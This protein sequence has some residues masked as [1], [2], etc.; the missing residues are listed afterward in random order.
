MLNG[1]KFM[2]KNNIKRNSMFKN[3]LLIFGLV[4]ISTLSHSQEMKKQ[5]GV[6]L[7]SDLWYNGVYSII[8]V[9]YTNQR[10]YVSLGSTLLD[11]NEFKIRAKG[12]NCQYRVYPN[13]PHKTFNLFFCAGFNFY[14]DVD[15]WNGNGFRYYA[16]APDSYRASYENKTI[17]TG[18]NL[19]FGFQLNFTKNFYFTTSFNNLSSYSITKNKVVVQ[20]DPIDILQ[21]FE[22]DKRIFS[23]MF[24]VSFGYNFNFKKR[25][26]KPGED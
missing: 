6:N 20:K 2:E 13:L 25:V 17:R 7:S 3:K 22:K 26:S 1:L 21:R 4:I 14:R 9:N 8:S 16:G 23:Q 15:R 11:F 24:S 19:G 5:I 12:V 10:H 18:V